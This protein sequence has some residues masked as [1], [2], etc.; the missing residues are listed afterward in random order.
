M[1]KLITYN[2]LFT[3]TLMSAYTLVFADSDTTTTVNSASINTPQWS[4]FCSD[5][6]CE[7]SKSLLPELKPQPSA[8]F[9]VLCAFV[10]ILL[11]VAYRKQ[12]QANNSEKAWRE[13]TEQNYWADRRTQFKAE[14]SQ[15]QQ[16][17]AN[18]K[19]IDC[20]MNVRQMETSKNQ[21]HQQELLMRQQ[22]KAIRSIYPNYYRY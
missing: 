4:E 3:I 12:A 5:A 2:L 8:G 11:P 13:A 22:I 16:V 15:C 18:D 1:K 10:P 21:G 19:L 14:V 7:S 6:Y 17:Q 20:Y 9:T